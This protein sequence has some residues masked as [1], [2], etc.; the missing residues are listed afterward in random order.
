M[1]NDPQK[2]LADLDTIDQ[3]ITSLLMASSFPFTFRAIFP[4]SSISFSI[5]FLIAEYSLTVS[6][7]T[8]IIL[9][10]KLKDKL[11]TQNW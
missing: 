6:V 10:N 1:G 4:T 2:K 3:R 9:R 7:V 8:S 11:D 5:R